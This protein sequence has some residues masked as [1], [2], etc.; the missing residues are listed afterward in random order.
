MKDTHINQ[1]ALHVTPP[2]LRSRGRTMHL[3]DIENL[4]GKTAFTI[5]EVA[6]LEQRY[7]EVAN[8]GPKDQVVIASSH[9][10]AP[11][12]WMGWDRTARRLVGSGPDGADIALIDVLEREHLANR[13]DHVVLGSGDGIF[14][15]HCAKLQAAGC[16]VS[17]VSRR[18]S[19]SRRLRLA[20]RDI[21]FLDLEIPAVVSPRSLEAA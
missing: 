4:M 6:W 7:V 3:I 21:N 1:M 17:V 19:I 18:E 13:F 20:V 12:T 8:L 2:E 14:S 10:A 16:G 15:V 11:P 9:F 5:Q